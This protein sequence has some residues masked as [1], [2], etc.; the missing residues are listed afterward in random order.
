MK[1]AMVIEGY[2]PTWPTRCGGS[3]ARA[4]LM[5]SDARDLCH[6]VFRTFPA[7]DSENNPEG[8]D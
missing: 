6:K 1:T 7:S 2:W 5:T 8:W 3:V 4:G